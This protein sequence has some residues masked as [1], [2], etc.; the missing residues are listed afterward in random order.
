M[1]GRVT[2]GGEPVAGTTLSIHPSL[3][4]GRG[5]FSS[6]S[7]ETGAD[8]TFSVEGVAPGESTVVVD[9]P[10]ERDGIRSRVT[11]ETAIVVPADSDPV[12]EISVP[13][14]GV[15]GRVRTSPANRPL[16]SAAIEVE[17]QS[18]DDHGR[19]GGSATTDRDG[20]FRLAGLPAGTYR[21]R[22]RGTEE[23]GCAPGVASDVVVADGALTTVE[24][25]LQEEGRALVEVVDE[26]GEPVREAW[27]TLRR[28][29]EEERADPRGTPWVTD[30][31][32]LARMRRISPGTYYASAGELG[33]FVGF[34]D[35]G[36]VLPGRE[37]RFRIRLVVG[38]EARVAVLDA[39]GQPVVE[40]RVSFLDGEKRRVGAYLQE[41]E[42]VPPE[43][44]RARARLV[45]GEYLLRV[46]AEGF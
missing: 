5:L 42:G 6:R 16:F 40:P 23:D 35:K 45:P 46:S 3:P 4:G 26:R 31:G 21:V 14:G 36:T 29:E 33:G 11:F 17:P 12:L 15:E 37:T 27:V 28:A 24:F 22:A 10:G 1:R 7:A 25:A 20:R 32:G 43:R 30:S 2:R 41:E 44:R 38:V 18:G 39:G 34:S 8:G 9:A 13:T 19:R